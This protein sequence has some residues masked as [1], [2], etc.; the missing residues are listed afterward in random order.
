VSGFLS[1]DRVFDEEAYAAGTFHRARFTGAASVVFDLDAG[2]YHLVNE[3]MRLVPESERS[4]SY[5]ELA[6]FT[7]AEQVRVFGWCSCEDCGV[8]DQPFAD[9]PRREAGGTFE[10]AGGAS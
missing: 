8:G 2:V 1:G 6:D 7:H 4:I 10:D 9:C 5:G 3:D